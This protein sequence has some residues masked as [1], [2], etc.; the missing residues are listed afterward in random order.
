MA[1][2]PELG[3]SPEATPE[4]GEPAGGAEMALE[5]ALETALETALESVVTPD[6]ALQSEHRLEQ[7]H[8]H[9]AD[10]PIRSG[11]IRSEQ[12]HSQAADAHTLHVEDGAIAI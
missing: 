11:P 7:P 5:M 2:Q 3:Q 6:T 1:S 12:P 4:A 9:A 8:S 10:A